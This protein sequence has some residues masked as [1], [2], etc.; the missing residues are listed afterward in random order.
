MTRSER[1]ALALQ[2]RA[3]DVFITSS[4]PNQLYF[5]NHPE[6]SS[7]ISRANCRAIVF[8]CEVPVVFPGVWISNACRDLLTSCEVVE[9]A[10]GDPPPE[11]QLLSYLQRAGWKRIVVDQQGLADS[12]QGHLGATEILVED[13]G[14]LLRRT[15][16]AVDLAGMREAARIADLGMTAAF[17]A[18]RPGLNCLDVIAE[19]E[20][21][22]LKAGAEDAHMAP[23]VGEGTFYLDSAENPRRTIRQGDMIFIDMAIHVRGYLGDMTRAGIVGEGTAEQRTLLETVQ[24]AYRTGAEAMYPGADGADIYRRVVACFAEQ[25]WETYY[26]HHLSHGLGLGGDAPRIGREIADVLQVGD[27]LS[28]EPGI[29]VPGLGGARVENMIYVGPDGPE[30]LTK[31]PLD[32]PMDL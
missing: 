28:C 8:G 9:N 11:A 14:A 6:P 24:R 30:A 26:V 18:I 22:M 16:D 25:G 10:L 21:A 2:E 19:G 29:Y 1:L 20:Y 31:C 17:A 3:A 15:K 5:L 12:L 4:R 7:V 27:A 13:V 32:L 23:A